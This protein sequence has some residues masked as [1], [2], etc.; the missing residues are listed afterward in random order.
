LLEK[1]TFQMERFTKE[2]PGVLENVTV[3]RE[4]WGWRSVFRV[5]KKG[6][7]PDVTE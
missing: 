1:P 3:K 7:F 4:H 6:S 2:G 5:E